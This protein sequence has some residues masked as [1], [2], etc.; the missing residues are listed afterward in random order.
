MHSYVV[1]IAQSAA[2]GS[3]VGDPA[4]VTEF[5]T[6]YGFAFKRLPVYRVAFP[7]RVT[8]FADPADGNIAAV[9]DQS[10]RAEGWIFGYIHKLDWLVPFTGTDMRDAIAMTLA[11]LLAGAALLGLT[12]SWQQGRRTN[13][14]NRQALWSGQRPRS[15]S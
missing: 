4:M 5:N 15:P 3:A 13:A 14:S 1:E 11:L 9:I 8:V 2:A 6:E 10:D 12:L 7:N